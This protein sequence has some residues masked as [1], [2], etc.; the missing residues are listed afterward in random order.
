MIGPGER[1]LHLPPDERATVLRDELIK[2]LTRLVWAYMDQ[3]G[4]P[5]DPV[6]LEV[7]E[8]LRREGWLSVKVGVRK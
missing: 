3:D 7:F 4:D 8:A 6:A 2:D 1:T 5:I